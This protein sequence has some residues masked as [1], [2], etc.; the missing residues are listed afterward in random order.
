MDKNYQNTFDLQYKICYCYVNMI[1]LLYAWM[2]YFK[3][4]FTGL[5]PSQPADSGCTQ[6]G[7]SGQQSCHVLFVQPKRD[8]KV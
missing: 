8:I 3:Y 7:K 5:C 2:S 6:G 1:Q 4:L